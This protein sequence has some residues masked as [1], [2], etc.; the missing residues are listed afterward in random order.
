MPAASSGGSA[1][2][3]GSTFGYRLAQI[4]IAHQR[5]RRHEIF[6]R[7]DRLRGQGPGFIDRAVGGDQ[8]YEAKLPRD[9]KLP[10]GGHLFQ[11]A[12]HG[13]QFRRRPIGEQPDQVEHHALVLVVGMLILTPSGVEQ[14]LQL[15]FVFELRQP[16]E[17]LLAELISDAGAEQQLQVDGVVPL[18]LQQI[19]G[20]HRLEEVAGRDRIGERHVPAF[21]DSPL[22]VRIEGLHRFGADEIE[23][24]VGRRRVEMSGIST[25]RASGKKLAARTASSRTR[26]PDRRPASSAGRS[27]LA[28]DR[29]NSKARAWRRPER[30]SLPS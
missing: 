8:G 11:L 3:R 12:A 19:V 30:G 7:A 20:L 16:V 5:H 13:R 29:A 2:K 15:R 21:G 4:R 26:R 28:P 6:Q 24:L 18:H 25:A 1:V 27:R 14:H 23:V 9:R 10:V 22:H 17:R